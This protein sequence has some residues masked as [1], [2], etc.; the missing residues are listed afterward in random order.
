MA[1]G[2]NQRIPSAD[3]TNGWTVVWSLVIVGAAIVLFYVSNREDWIRSLGWRTTL[4]QVAGVFVATGILS[5]GWELLGKRRFAIEVLAKAQLSAEIVEA[6]IT[7]VS[8]QYLEDVEWADLFRDATKV[9]VVVA[10][11]NTWRNTHAHR[12]REVASRPGTRLRVYLL[13]PDDPET[14]RSHAERFN[15][16]PER[17][18]GQ[19]DDAIQFYSGLTTADGG[20]V[21]VYVRPGERVF[22]AYRFDSHAVLTLYSHGKERRTSVPTFVVRGGSLWKFVYDEIDSIREQSRKVF[23]V[24]QD[25]GEGEAR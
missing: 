24:A 12:L 5:V 18:A 16:T 6:G 22:S 21:E 4:N 20:V 7:H 17:L 19:I 15:S 14:M 10:Y 2:K 8:N 3:S 23:P 11:A 13:D 1:L 25:C 9:D